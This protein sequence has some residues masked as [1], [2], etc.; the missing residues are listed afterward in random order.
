MLTAVQS[1]DTRLP[2]G[3][4]HRMIVAVDIEGSTTR[5]N[6]AKGELRRVLY[7]LI[8]HALEGA[9]ISARHLEPHTDRGDSVLILIRPHDDIPKTTILTRLIPML[10]ALL[11]DHNLAAARPELRIRMRA[12]VHAGEVHED[13]RGFYGDDLD[14]AFRLLE[15]PRLK[16]AL[17]EAVETPLLLVVSEEI[18]HGIVEQGYLDDGPYCQMIRIRVGRRQR[19]GWVHI[20]VPLPFDRPGPSRRPRIP[21]LA[22]PL[23]IAPADAGPDQPDG[24]GQEAP[25][26]GPGGPDVNGPGINGW[27]AHRVN[28][29][30]AR[31]PER[32]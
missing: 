28:G 24:A 13:A 9:G 1:L 18:Y 21:P 20:P 7:E 3:P 32:G 17:K 26:D 11:I 29:R 15:A 14:S 31:R 23:A 25:E 27:G 19:R 30:A 12:V 5:N 4:V 2:D 6:P 22:A 8:E 16:K 10:T